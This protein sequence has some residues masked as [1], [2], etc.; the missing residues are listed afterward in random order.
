MAVLRNGKPIEELD[1][2]SGE[3]ERAEAMRRWHEGRRVEERG[4]SQSG[5]NN[6]WNS[7]RSWKHN[8]TMRV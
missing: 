2:D 1:H 7:P 5:L 6:H 4:P 3:P 8:R